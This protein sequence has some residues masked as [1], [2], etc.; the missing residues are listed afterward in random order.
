MLPL[1]TFTTFTSPKLNVLIIPILSTLWEG[2]ALI[3]KRINL[4]LPLQLEPAMFA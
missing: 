3:E 4:L 2:G 1:R